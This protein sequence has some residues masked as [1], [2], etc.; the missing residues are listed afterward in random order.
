MYNDVVSHLLLYFVNRFC[1]IIVHTILIHFVLNRYPY[2]IFYLMKTEN[3]Q[4]FI[5]CTHERFI[6]KL[7]SR[8]GVSD[9][10]CFNGWGGGGGGVWKFS[11]A[12]I[13]FWNV[14]PAANNFFVSVFPQKLFF[15]CIQFIS[16][17]TACAN[18]LFQN[19]PTPPLPIK[20]I[21]VY[22]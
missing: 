7:G 6:C 11:H 3:K 1:H 15:T 5:T 22:P 14:A 4:N 16:V 18:K 13:F 10:H 12:S 8:L 21:M 2:L 20:T 9:H 19:F 17:F